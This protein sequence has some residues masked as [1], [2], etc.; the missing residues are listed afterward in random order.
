MKK[1]RVVLV[2]YGYWGKNILRCLMAEP[3]IEVVCVCDKNLGS[4]ERAQEIYPSLSVSDDFHREITSELCDAVVVATPVKTHF[5]IAKMAITNKKHVLVEKPICSSSA[6]AAELIFLAKTHGV[7]LMV[8]HTYLFHPVVSQ[9]KSLIDSGEL[10]EIS[11]LDSRRINLGLFQPDVDVVWDLAPHDFSVAQYL[12]GGVPAHVHAT[13]YCHVNEGLPDMAYVTTNFDNNTL[14]HFNLS[15]MSPTK[16]REMLI[17]GSKRMA[18]WNDLDNEQPLKVY[19]SGISFSPAHE[20]ENVIPTYRLGSIFSPK[21]EREEP[22]AQVMKHFSA[23]VT[24]KE[25]SKMDGK[26]GYECVK[27]LEKISESIKINQRAK[28]PSSLSETDDLLKMPAGKI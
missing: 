5:A 6:E 13:G 16:K 4:L 8:D 23:V 3:S 18:V 7:T 28:F 24:G 11:Y 22:L 10:G 15:W 2:G 25:K 9:I 21:L 19:D 27:F 12:L 20:R 14:A 26:K 1:V 17:G